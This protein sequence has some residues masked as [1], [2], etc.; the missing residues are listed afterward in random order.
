MHRLFPRSS[1]VAGCSTY[2][3]LGLL[4][5]LGDALLGLCN[6]KLELLSLLHGGDRARELELLLLLLVRRRVVLGLD[7]LQLLPLLLLQRQL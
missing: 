5:E 1:S 3:L 2:Q 7:R 4:L 6:L